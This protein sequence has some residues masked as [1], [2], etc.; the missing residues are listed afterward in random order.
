MIH[1]GTSGWHYNHWKGPFYPSKHRQKDFLSF[2]ADRFGTVEI[3]NSFYRLPT[4]DALKTW[5]SS[6]P[7][8]FIFS[9]KA[10]RYITHMKK[11]K[12]VE[13][14][15]GS[16]LERVDLLKPKLG[17]ILFQLPGKW[18][19]N[20][21]RFF[22]FLEMLP[23]E[24]RYAFEFRDPSWQNPEAHA[25]MKTLGVAFCIF[26]IDHYLSPKETTADFIYVRLHGPDGAYKGK[27][28][29]CLLYGWAGAF[30]T[31]SDMGME[32]FCYFDNDDRGYAPG[33]ARLLQEMVSTRYT[34]V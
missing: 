10:S 11:L 29:N 20:K 9:V 16:F 34:P 15:L 23:G 13:K 19:F 1:I 31:W 21:E 22:E 26:E 24:Y 12:G 32:I 25:A 28:G 2:Y 8:G 4:E 7:P 17:P 27:Y 30:S 33:D 5:E 18:R 6:V 3:N 14:A